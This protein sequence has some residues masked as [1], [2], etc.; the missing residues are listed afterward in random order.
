MYTHTNKRASIDICQSLV[1]MYLH[2]K[3]E[4]NR[5]IAFNVYLICAE[6]YQTS[7]HNNQAYSYL[8]QAEIITKTLDV[9]TNPRGIA[10][11]DRKRTKTKDILMK[12]KFQSDFQSQLLQ[13]QQQQASSEFDSFSKNKCLFNRCIFFSR[14]N[15]RR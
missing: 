6:A 7:G 8:Q 15:K 3:D 14:F 10:E 4:Y 12:L 11:R 13:N 9:V 1:R 2:R 5:D